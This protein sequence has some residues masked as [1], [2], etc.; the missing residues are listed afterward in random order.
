[1]TREGRRWAS[2]IAAVRR[3]AVRRVQERCDDHGGAS[4]M[5]MMMVVVKRRQDEG[6]AGDLRGASRLMAPAERQ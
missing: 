3:I 1:M 4:I 6:G 2:V 5:M